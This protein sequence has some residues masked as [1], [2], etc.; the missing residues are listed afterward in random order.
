MELFLRPVTVPG[1][2]VWKRKPGRHLPM[3]L[4]TYGPRAARLEHRHLGF[5][6]VQP[7]QDGASQRSHR[8]RLMHCPLRLLAQRASSPLSDAAAA[9]D[10]HVCSCG[11]PELAL[12][13]AP[14]DFLAGNAGPAQ[15]VALGRLTRIAT[16]EPF[17]DKVTQDHAEIDDIV[18]GFR[19]FI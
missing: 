6:R 4:R 1:L 2:A 11:P 19:G 18:P 15:A 14:T 8:L 16:G 7:A 9:R 12:L 17:I 5:I 3:R 13:S 10:V